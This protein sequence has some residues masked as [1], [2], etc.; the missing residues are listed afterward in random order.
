MKA[1]CK[2]QGNTIFIVIKVGIIVSPSP[3]LFS[4]QCSVMLPVFQK[5]VLEGKM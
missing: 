4:E 5:G 1:L 3:L 2:L